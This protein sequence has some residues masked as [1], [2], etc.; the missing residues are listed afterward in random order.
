M[1]SFVWDEN[2]VTNI[3]E[4]DSQHQVL[5]GLINEYSDM[6]SNN[7]A[8]EASTKRI[9]D[10]L[11]DYTIYHFSE[12][13]SLMVECGLDPRHIDSHK[14]AH[15]YFIDEIVTM[16]ED[17]SKLG[18]SSGHYLLDFLMHWLA[19][20]ILGLDQVMSGQLKSL[21]EGYTAEEAYI[22]EE[23]LINDTRGP[24]L[25]ALSALFNQVSERNQRLK[26]LMTGLELKVKDRT[27]E[28][29]GAYLE[30]QIA[31]KELE[32]ISITD[33]L[34]DLP[35]RRHAISELSRLWDDSKNN[36]LPL[37]CMMIDADNFKIINDTQGHDCGDKVLVALAN[38]LKHSV[39]TDDIVCRFGGDEFLVICPNTDSLVTQTLA[40]NML[41]DVRKLNIQVGD[42]YWSGSVS[43]GIATSKAMMD[44]ADELIKCAD[45]AVYESKNNGKNGYSVF[46]HND[47]DAKLS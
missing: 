35:N 29:Q 27:Q 31:N 46:N 33:I 6:L 3:E 15:Q 18:Q 4:V 1:A 25:G 38:V 32:A 5:V 7:L 42:S 37:S 9:L 28:L 43:I 34:T 16:S 22:K 14:K 45:L 24:L 20:H 17:M 40:A 8:S 10:E 39:R 19:Y 23:H 12:E 36:D 13:E 11:L 44:S 2:F 26:E 21:D 47:H 41:I 30:L